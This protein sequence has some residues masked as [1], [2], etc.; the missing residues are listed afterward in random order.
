MKTVKAKRLITSRGL[1]KTGQVTSYLVGDDGQYEAGW[2]VGQKI[3]DNKTRFILKAIGDDLVTIDKATGLMWASDGGEEGCYDAR[4]ESWSDCII[5]AEAI[6][7]AGF[8]DWRLPNI[9]ELM[10]IVDYSLFEPCIDENFFPNTTDNQ[11][12]SSTTDQDSNTRAF[13][14][15]FDKGTVNSVAKSASVAMRAVRGGLV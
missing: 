13:T 15:Y 2:W 1:P 10:S 9:K 3:A 4:A 8:L 5:W 6:P 11:F 12:W 14:V 7:F